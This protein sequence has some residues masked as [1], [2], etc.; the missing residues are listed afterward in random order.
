MKKKTFFR[1]I[2]TKTCWINQTLLYGEKIYKTYSVDGSDFHYPE[3]MDL[4]E[5]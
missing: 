3:G 1:L 5:H 2:S 4:P